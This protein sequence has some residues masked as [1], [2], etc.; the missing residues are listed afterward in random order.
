MACAQNNWRSLE[1]SRTNN[2]LLEVCLRFQQH[3]SSYHRMHEERKVPWGE[4]A[5][6]S[7]ELIKEKL[8]TT[9]VL[10]LPD[11]KKLFEIECDASIVGIGAVLTQE[12]KPLEFFSEKLGE[13]RQKWSTY[14]QELYAILRALKVWEHYLIQ[15]E[16]I[17]YTDY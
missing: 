10:V 7:F 8:C 12:G 16:F 1:L 3:C 2:L 17:L 4:E 6:R 14:K 9:L 15:R 13:T 11:F 5:E